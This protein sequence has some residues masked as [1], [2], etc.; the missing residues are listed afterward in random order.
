M[1]IT[2]IRPAQNFDEIDLYLNGETEVCPFCDGSGEDSGVTPDGDEWSDICEH[3]DGSGE[4]GAITYT[5]E[6]ILKQRSR[7]DEDNF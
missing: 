2:D 3:C 6:P 1:P 4:L 7:S 5:P